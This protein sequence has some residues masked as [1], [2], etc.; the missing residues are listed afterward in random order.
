MHITAIPVV[1]A[2]RVPFH[3]PATCR[4][5]G[6]NKHRHLAAF[7]H[8]FVPGNTRQFQVIAE[9]LLPGDVVEKFE[10]KSNLI[11]VYRRP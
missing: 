1:P 2:Q 4:I 6:V 8:V 9:E 5:C 10:P 11:T 3:D 7:G